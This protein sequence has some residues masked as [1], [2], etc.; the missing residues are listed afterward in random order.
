MHD[1]QDNLYLMELR[2]FGSSLLRLRPHSSLILLPP[3]RGPSR[4]LVANANSFDS[5]LLNLNSSQSNAFSTYGSPI[6]APAATAAPSPTPDPDSKELPENTNFVRHMNTSDK[7]N[8]LIDE[9]GIMG[10]PVRRYA[11]SMGPL[12][13]HS[14]KGESSK[15]ESA[16]GDGSS[17]SSLDIFNTGFNRRSSPGAIHHQMMIPGQTRSDDAL[18]STGSPRYKTA[19]TP[20]PKP[21]KPRAVRTIESRPRVGRTIEIDSKTGIDV[22]VALRK[23][24]RACLNN[25]VRYDQQRQRHHERPGL[26]RKRLKRVRWRARFKQGFRVLVGKVLAMRSKGW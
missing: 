4:F 24:T 23:L 6:H 18:D 15:S 13:Y 21:F 3:L 10:G 7:V 5:V 16:K 1:L 9:V 12:S 25:N 19:R 8:L 2:S 22:A 26:K 11:A 17:S 20:P 14:S